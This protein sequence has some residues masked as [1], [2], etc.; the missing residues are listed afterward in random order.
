[1]IYCFDCRFFKKERWGGGSYCDGCNHP[2]NLTEH[3]PDR[4]SHRRRRKWLHINPANDRNRKNDC[5]DFEQ[6]ANK[7]DVVRC[8][9]DGRKIEW[10]MVQENKHPMPSPF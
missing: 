2:N 9:P 1:M 5:V 6:K 3:G 10:G 7:S 4:E 8:G